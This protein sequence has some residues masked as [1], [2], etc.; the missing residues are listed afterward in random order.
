ME[1]GSC[2]DAEGIMGEGGIRKPELPSGGETAVGQE[3]QAWSRHFWTLTR[4]DGAAQKGRDLAEPRMPWLLGLSPFPRTT[5][6]ALAIS[7]FPVSSPVSL[8]LP[9]D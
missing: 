4:A 6:N 3:V 5:T 2:G 7:G 9:A 1:G 8:R